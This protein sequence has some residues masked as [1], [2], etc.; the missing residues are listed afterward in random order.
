MA[1]H[2]GVTYQPVEDAGAAAWFGGA[3]VDVWTKIACGPPGYDEY[4]RV[5]F[6]NETERPD[7]AEP[8]MP[9]VV[10]ILAAHT[11]TSEECFVALWEGNGGTTPPGPEFD[12]FD[13]LLGSV[14]RYVLLSA[15]AGRL[16]DVGTFEPGEELWPEP[17]AVWPADRAWFIAADVD[18]EWCTVG[19]THKA[20]AALLAD[21][22]LDTEL[23][24]Y[25]ERL[26]ESG[27]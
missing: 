19:T 27:R 1:H 9:A 10:D 20:A 12:I 26:T 21:P 17:H 24:P 13:D 8:A 25:G 15:P 2:E 23:V 11:T 14:R 6:V 22:R 4:V 7:V 3:D 16:F 5:F 18:P